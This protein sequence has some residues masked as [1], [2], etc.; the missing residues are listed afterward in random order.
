MMGKKGKWK[1]DKIFFED[2][3]GMEGLFN[4]TL[5]NTE[6]YRKIIKLRVG[7]GKYKTWRTFALLHRLL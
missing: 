2:F 7:G 6:N 3:I 1:A 5:Y 4:G